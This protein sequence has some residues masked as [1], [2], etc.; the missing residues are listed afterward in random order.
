MNIH[1]ALQ[2]M[3]DEAEAK[4][5]KMIA[6]T[7]ASGQVQMLSRHGYA[8]REEATAALKPFSTFIVSENIA[9]RFVHS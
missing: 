9:G 2:A 3:L 5:A 8:T 1:P 4:T 7:I 6:D